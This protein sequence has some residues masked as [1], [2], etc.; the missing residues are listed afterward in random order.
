MS[1]GLSINIISFVLTEVI[2]D[3]FALF[4]VTQGEGLWGKITYASA[5]PKFS[6]EIYP[7]LVTVAVARQR[8]KQLIYIWE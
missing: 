4:A 6:G 5:V 1:V 7:L 2:T 8:S 3:T